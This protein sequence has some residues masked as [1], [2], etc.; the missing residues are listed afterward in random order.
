MTCAGLSPD[1]I[2]YLPAQNPAHAANSFTLTATLDRRRVRHVSS[3]GQET[4]L[5]SGVFLMRM[6]WP[7]VAVFVLFATVMVRSDTFTFQDLTDSVTV[8][9]D[10]VRS[11]NFN[12]V[13]EDCTLVLGEPS[14]GAAGT[15]TF[16]AF[17]LFISEANGVTLSDSV[18]AQI[19]A[20]SILGCDAAAVTAGLPVILFSSDV[21]S[22]TFPCGLFFSCVPEDGTIQTAGTVTWGDGTVDTINFQ[23]DVEA[24]PEPSSLALLGTG[25]FSAIAVA[26]KKLSR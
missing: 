4:G 6:N 10:S 22:S 7:M 18:D 14:A 17:P 1:V 24:V 20:P 19:C 21:D 16:S 2:I 23:S 8:S 26:R 12:C 13:L 9:I 3:Q 25:L 5:H 11:F 15:I